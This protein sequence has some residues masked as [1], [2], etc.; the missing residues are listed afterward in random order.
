MIFRKAKQTH[1]VFGVVPEVLPDS[2]V[3][4]GELDEEVARLLNRRTH[5]A[6]RGESKCGKSWLRQKA[7]PHAL[8]V[9]CRL[10]KTML[11]IYTDALS[12]LGVELIVERRE[13]DRLSGRIE[14]S[15]EAGNSLL[16][17]IGLKAAVEGQTEGATTYR[18]VGQDL[19]DLKFISDLLLASD[20]RL[21]IEDFHYLSQ[22]ER[23][24]CAFDLKTMW[25]YGHF[26]V[27]VGIWNER[28]LFLNLNPDLSGRV[29]EVAIDWNDADL[30]HIFEKGG[31]ALNIEFSQEIQSR[32]VRD[33][34]RN[35]GILQR[36]IIGTLDEA[37]I[38]EGSRDTVRIENE[39]AYTAACMAYAEEL[40]AVYQTF[41]QRVS[42]GIRTRQDATGIYPHAMAVVLDESTDDEL[43]R[44][45]PIAKIYEKSHA[46]QPRIQR[47]NLHT[48]L[49][50]IEGM[51]VD[52][53][54]RG[55][56]L[57]YNERDQE[58]T[59]VDRQLLLYRR[60]STV[61]WPWEDLIKEA[62]ARP[63]AEQGDN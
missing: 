61:R 22:E 6:L 55:L 33:C 60:Y 62:E 45:V 17:K 19:N 18:A 36:L 37:K 4:R 58:V 56:V 38:Y 31:R 48:I 47:G 63:E 57:A 49:G 46:R 15:G 27:I 39:D 52:S 51:Q 21:V 43:F 14:A 1:E 41:A 30:R 3:D 2:Y 8:V 16:V 28:N 35:A 40:N 25:D 20:R 32:A 29:T 54:G 12:Q 7:L 44:G 26:V 5:I 11:D 59:V 24:V 9:Q 34:F 42:S 23:R 13:G 50:R 53:D 10:G